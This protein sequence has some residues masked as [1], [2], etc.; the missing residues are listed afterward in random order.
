MLVSGRA[1]T[2]YTL[3]VFIFLWH[4]TYCFLLLLRFLS[5]FK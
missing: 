1:L 3:P 4:E 5:V 2:T